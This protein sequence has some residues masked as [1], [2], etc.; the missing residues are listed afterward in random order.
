MAFWTDQGGSLEPK[1]TF[2]WV[3]RIPTSDTDKTLLDSWII[4]KV[5]RPTINVASAE[6][7]FL[8]HTFYYP[9]RVTYEPV[10]FTLVDP[11]D[12]DAAYRILKIIENS[13]YTIPTVDTVGTAAGLSTISKKESVATLAN[14]EITQ[15]D[16]EG[17]DLEKWKFVNPWVQTI[18]FSELNY[19][20]DDLTT[21]DVTMR[22]DRCIFTPGPNG[23]APNDILFD[24]NT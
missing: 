8:N 17:K 7:A 4:T 10:T 14:M 19:E 11:I 24:T 9:G 1:R 16:A 20:N 2:R 13:G 12:V 22:Y 5:S 15:V 6:H 23:P 3:L 21:I 18:A